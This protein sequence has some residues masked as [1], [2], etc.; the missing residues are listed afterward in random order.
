MFT[1]IFIASALRILLAFT[2]Y[3]AFF[4]VRCP[5]GAKITIPLAITQ[6]QKLQMKKN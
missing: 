4:N 5:I 3:F 6:Y 1:E 2:F